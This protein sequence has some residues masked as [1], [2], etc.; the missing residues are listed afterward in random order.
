VVDLLA[1][2]C[3][4]KAKARHLAGPLFS[5]YFYFIKLEVTKMPVLAGLFFG[6]QVIDLEL[7]RGIRRRGLE[8]FGA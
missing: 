4:L 1:L 7:V 2:V 8:L 5:I 6:L 3:G